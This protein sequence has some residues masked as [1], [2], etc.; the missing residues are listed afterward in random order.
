MPT[1]SFDQRGRLRD[2]VIINRD[3]FQSGASPG[4]KAGAA[5]AA[6]EELGFK[7]TVNN[8][9]SICRDMNEPWPRGERESK[10]KF[11]ILARE[12]KALGGNSKEF[13][14]EFEADFK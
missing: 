4:G 3:A 2:W 1:L 11:A 9:D 13:N 7:V 6:T 12:I 10:R 8:I 14:Q 5:E